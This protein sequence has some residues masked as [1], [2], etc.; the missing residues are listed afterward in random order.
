MLAGLELALD[1]MQVSAAEARAAD[2][3]D[4]VEWRGDLRLVDFFDGLGDC[5]SSTRAC[6]TS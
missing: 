2:A 5:A 1:N 4:N 3:H 6:A